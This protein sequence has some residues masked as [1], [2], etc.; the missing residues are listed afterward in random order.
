MQRY[1]IESPHTDETCISILKDAMAAGFLR[2]F[3][4]GCDDDVH[5][6]WAIIEA[7]STE[8]ARMAVPPLMRNDAKVVKLVK[9]ENDYIE[10]LHHS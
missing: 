3:D 6:G 5:C 1:L 7:E 10:T 8:Q 2:H 4:W 9:Y